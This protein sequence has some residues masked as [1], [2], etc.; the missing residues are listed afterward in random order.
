MPRPPYTVTSL[1]AIEEVPAVGGTLRWKPVRRTLGVRAFGV[2][3]YAA[4]AGQDVVEEHDETGAGAGGHEELYVVVRGRATFTLDGAEHDA[5]AG[6]L[7]FAGDPAVRRFARAIEDG[8]LILAVGA[9]PAAPYEVSPWESWFLAEA[10]SDAGDHDA[11]LA[12]MGDAREAHAG[13]PAFHY[14]HAVFLARAGRLDDAAA[15]LR[16]AVAADRERV[17]RWAASDPDLGPLRE[18]PDWPLG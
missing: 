12:I 4:D 11:A 18:R 2:N 17:E 9:D 15:E 13:N 1:D 10:R 6:S 14:N 7:V 5:P 16:A 8:T 3:A